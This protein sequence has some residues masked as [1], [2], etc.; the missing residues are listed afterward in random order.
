[1]L[2]EHE[3]KYIEKIKSGATR[4]AATAYDPHEEKAF[5]SL[6]QRG[7]LETPHKL[8]AEG[9][10]AHT[11]QI[12]KPRAV[13][14]SAKAN[15]MSTK[16]KAG[17][18]ASHWAAMGAH[19][20]AS[21]AHINLGDKTTSRQHSAASLVHETAWRAAGGAGPRLTARQQ[22]LAAHG[23]DPHEK[24]SGSLKAWAKQKGGAGKTSAGSDD[25]PRDEKGQ[26]SSK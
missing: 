1:M 18:A 5:G 12:E 11:E 23:M 4:G 8:S 21:N 16:A 26:F 22:L 13:A 15:E 2:N 14:L 9:E 6:R 3:K 24:E 25:H 20:Q 17:D 19:N 7:L 10:K